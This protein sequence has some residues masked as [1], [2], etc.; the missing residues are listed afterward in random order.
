MWSWTK[1]SPLKWEDAW[2]ERI[3]GNPNSVIE[4]IKGGKTIRITVYCETEAEATV[5][6]DYFGGSMREVKT[7]DWISCQNREKKPPLRIRDSLLITEQTEERDL[8]AIRAEFPGRALLS[9]PAEMAFGTGDHATTSTCLRL[10]SDFAR[11]HRQENWQITDIGCGTAVLSIAAILLGASRGTAFDFDGI[12]V[13]VSNSNARRNGLTNQQIDIFRGDVF[14]WTPEEKQ[15]GN[16]VVANLFSTILQKAF[17]Q[18]IETMLPEA[19]L[20]IS[21]ILATQWDETRA[22]AQ[23]CGLTFPE[24]IKKGKWVTARGF[25][26][27][28]T[29][30]MRKK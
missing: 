16:L 29:F 3:A 9:I 19:T 18:I 17:P 5:L 21:G 8:E 6:K 4:K 13:D 7:R 10:I 25:L 2:S 24:V 11:K 12:A 20:I 26:D 22:A 23:K 1:L 30:S 27:T 15:K 28:S 14:E